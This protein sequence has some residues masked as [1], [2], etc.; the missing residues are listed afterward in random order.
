M[1]G[2]TRV[3]EATFRTA[4]F[5]KFVIVGRTSFTVFFDLSSGRIQIERFA[6]SAADHP[7]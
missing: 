1:I 6:W 5:R 3:R 7:Q 2:A 4:F